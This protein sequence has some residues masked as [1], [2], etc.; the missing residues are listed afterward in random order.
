MIALTF[1]YVTRFLALSFG[2][3]E[4]S[5]SKVK[6]SMEDAA[7]SLGEG[8][9]GILRRVHFPIIRASLLAAALLVFVDGMKELPMTVILR[10]FNFET[11]ATFVYQY[12]SDELLEEAALAALTIV[13]AGVLPVI[14]L[15]YGL[16]H[17]RPGDRN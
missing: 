12:A 8:P 15:S 13:A 17:T 7:R 5:L 6:P 16:R 2:A 9:V 1:G 4:S 10:P 3:A 14:L 11:L